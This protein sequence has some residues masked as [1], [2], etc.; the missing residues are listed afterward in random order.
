M[1]TRRI[2]VKELV[3]DIR[4]G[5]TDSELIS[6]YHL[7]SDQL[8]NV[9]KKLIDA[10]VLKQSDLNA[11]TPL[12]VE[13]DAADQYRQLERV[14][15][16][17]TVPVFDADDLL[18]EGALSDATE[19]GVKITGIEAKVDEIR[20]FLIQADDFP[21]VEPFEFDAR[22]AW[23]KAGDVDGVIAGGWEIT[24]ISETNLGEL[25]KLIH[26][27]S[28]GE[29]EERVTETQ[30]DKTVPTKPWALVRT[31]IG[32]TSRILNERKLY[33]LGAIGVVVAIILIFL[34]Q[35][36]RHRDKLLMEA[37]EKGRTGVVESLLDRGADVNI[38]DVEGRTP[39]ML[40]AF[41]GR[42]P[43]MRLLLDRSADPNA[44]DNKG[45]TA[46]M[47]AAF[48]GHPAA[49]ELLIDRGADVNAGSHKGGTA[50]IRAAS[51][52]HLEVVRFL[53]FKGADVNAE[54]KKGLSALSV[55]SANHFKDI[56]TL[57]MAYGAK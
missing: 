45:Y 5:I 19:K 27:V 30:P 53:L 57:L 11:R 6:K 38:T 22:C 40:A 48:K 28:V 12:H 54:T 36:Y 17:L 55:A 24:L 46:L 2:S 43:V 1:A 37:C 47:M 7:S 4:S 23:C 52:G 44:A 16:S 41:R 3:R 32:R 20:T 34:V 9:F 10:G 51:A 56:S 33:V 14:E 35:P 8:R 29:T 50:L 49:T 26:A 42:T 18:V 25:R 21:E 39:L 13:T 31:W 15:I